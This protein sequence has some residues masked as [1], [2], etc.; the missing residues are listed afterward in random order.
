MKGVYDHPLA[1]DVRNFKDF[2]DYIEILIQ[3]IRIFIS[4][5]P[6]SLRVK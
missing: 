4:G 2:K 5:N 3:S 6:I 1:H